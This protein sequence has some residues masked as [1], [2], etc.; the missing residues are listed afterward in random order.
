MFPAHGSTIT[1]AMR[2]PNSRKASATFSSSLKGTTTVADA[3]EAGT[4]P[5]SG[6]P[7]VRA[8]LPAFTSMLSEWPW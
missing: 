8:P 7:R 3:T 4:P 6:F 5:L 2:P 1:A